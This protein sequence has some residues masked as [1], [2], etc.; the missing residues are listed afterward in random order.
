MIPVHLAGQTFSIPT[1]IEDVTFAQF[2]AIPNAHNAS[3]AISVWLGC[4]LEIAE[5][6]DQEQKA[7]LLMGAYDLIDAIKEQPRTE[8]GYVELNSFRFP[9]PKTEGD[10]IWKQVY[11][12]LTEQADYFKS[13]A[14]WL[15]KE[16]ANQAATKA[17]LMNA[18]ALK[19]LEADFFFRLHAR[20]LQPWSGGWSKSNL[21]APLSKPE[22][23]SLI[24]TTDGILRRNGWPGQY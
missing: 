5:R 2:I 12:I 22:L 15:C 13:M 16:E 14:A 7:N 18:S 4:D 3:Q 10:L 19:M 24:V 20:I 9:I 8:L 17:A 21:T 1:K 23:S 6:I 11:V